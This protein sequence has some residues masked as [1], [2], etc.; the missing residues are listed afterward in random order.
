MTAKRSPPH[1]APREVERNS[2]RRAARKAAPQGRVLKGLAEYLDLSLGD[3][4]EGIALHAL[5]NKPPLQAIDPRKNCAVAARLRLRP[6]CR[7]QSPPPRTGWRRMMPVPI[8]PMEAQVTTLLLAFGALF[9]IVNP[10]SGAFIFFG[11]TRELDP[12]VRSRVSRWVA[13]YSFSIVTASLYIGAYV[14]SFFGISIPV[15][16]V[17]G[18]IIVAMSGWRMLNRPDATEQRR[19][20]TPSPRAPSDVMPAEPA[21]VL[22]AHHAAHY[23]PGNDFGGDFPRRRPPPRLLCRVARVLHRDAHRRGTAVPAGVRVLSKLGA[24]RGFDRRHGNHHRGAAV[25]V[26]TILYR[27]PGDVE[28]RGRTLEHAAARHRRHQLSGAGHCA[29]RRGAAGFVRRDGN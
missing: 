6:G 17:A 18:G 22:S 16:R 29:S 3:L 9:S 2:D 20:E 14:L 11:A 12:R 7:G 19:G 26:P 28:W 4:L 10:L 8:A 27:D 1:P 23:R 21:G 13:I 5:E 25:C 24:A 15:L